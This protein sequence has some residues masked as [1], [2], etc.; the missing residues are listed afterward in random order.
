[1]AGE[2]LECAQIGARVAAQME[3]EIEAGGG[4]LLDG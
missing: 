3:R 1:M 2:V 4:Y